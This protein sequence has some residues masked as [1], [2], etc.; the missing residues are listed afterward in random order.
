[1]MK[2]GLFTIIFGGLLLLGFTLRQEEDTV[3]EILESKGVDYSSKKPDFSIKGVSA[4]VGRKLFHDGITTKPNGGTTRRQSK[5][6]VCTSCHNAVIEDPDL[7]VSD[8]QARL[9]YAEAHDLPFLQGTTMYG[10]VNRKTYYN[11]D[12]YKKY[13]DL[14]YAARDN[15]REAIQLCATECAQGRKLKKWELESVLAYLWTLQL[16]PDDLGFTAEQLKEKSV[17]EIENMYISGS[18]ATFIPPPE[19][20]RKG[21]GIKG[22][23]A[24]GRLIYDRSCLHCHYQGRYSF[25]DLDHSKLSYNHLA[26][27]LCDY[28]RQ[29]IYQV[30]RWGVYPKSGKR[31]YMPQYTKERMSEKQLEDLRAFILQEA[32]K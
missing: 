25:Y 26:N 5:H 10:A 12:Y 4:E 31:S 24:N 3:I 6:F 19:N 1:M 27:N 15:I 2:R 30:V 8:P 23:P 11:G 29:S 7:R 14:V 28:S 32:R 17:E 22:D 18:P 20:R 21:A 16:R 9:E 13:G